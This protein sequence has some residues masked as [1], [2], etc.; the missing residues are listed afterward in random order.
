MMNLQYKWSKELLFQLI[1]IVIVF[2]FYSFDKNDPLIEGHEIAFFLTYVAAAMVVNY[3]LL[4]RF[5]YKKNYVAFFFWFAVLI[6]IVILL[7]EGVLEQIYYPDTRG[8]HV[9]NI[10]FN[11][12]DV[13]PPIIILSGFKFAWD[14]VIKQ[15]ELDEVK[16]QAQEG[17]LQLLKSQINP[18]FLFNNMN[19]LYAH[20]I[21]NSSKTPE[22]ILALSDFLRYTLYECK[23]RYVSINKE[24]EQLENFIQLN[25][26]HMEG[27]GSVSFSSD[28]KGKTFQIAPL[29]LMVFIE[30]AFKHS[31]SSQSENIEIAIRLSVDNAGLLVFECSNSFQEQSNTD[32]LSKG[33]GLK[34]VKKRLKLLYPKQHSLEISSKK[35]LFEVCLEIQLNQITP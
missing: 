26:M 34:N 25:E 8:K 23:A 22:I 31:T 3:V 24:I 30:N 5:L 9:P 13:L 4:D 15:K 6:S 33:I 29:L 21:E 27:R 2:L 14:A 32:N 20:A 11:L 19:N 10:F 16:L 7:E 18:H 12:L 35:E 17:E 28:I 1:L